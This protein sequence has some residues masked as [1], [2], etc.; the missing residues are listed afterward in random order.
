[1]PTY[2]RLAVSYLARAAELRKAGRLTESLAPLR[3]ALALEPNNAFICHDLG[4]TLLNCGQPAPAAEALSRAIATK[5]D[6]AAAHCRLG[7]ALAASG[8]PDKAIAAL[9]E[10]I[11]RDPQQ[12]EAHAALAYLLVE[13]GQRRAGAE[14]YRR[15][16]ALGRG[17][18]AGRI[19]LANALLIE[20]RDSEAESQLRRV[21]ALDPKNS[22]ARW[23]LGSVLSEG[24][25]FDL[26]EAE[27]AAAVAADPLQAVAW[28]DLVRCRRLGPADRPLID[29]MKAALP[30]LTR[31]DR[32]AL[33]HLA[34]GKA[35]DDLGDAGAAMRHFTAGNAAKP[36]P[37]QFDRRRLSERF[38]ALIARF[39]PELFD[40]YRPQANSSELPVLI[41]GLPRSGTTLVEQIVTSHPA[42]RGGGELLFW[43]H[44]ARAFVQV[45]DD[46]M[47]PYA[48]SRIAEEGLRVLREVDGAAMRITDKMPSNF[49]WAG[50][51]HLVFPFARIIH[52]R[53]SPIDTCLSMFQT[54][55]A[56]RPDFSTKAEDLVF[57]HAQYERL[58]AHWRAVLPSDRFFEVEYETLIA[59]SEPTTRRL[60]AFLGLEWDESCLHPERNSRRVK[61]ASKWQA[62]Q[63]IYTTALER[64]RRYE[65]FLG[66]FRALLPASATR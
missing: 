30:R 1:M 59:E 4:L 55:F 61:T 50:L 53:R 37:Y 11:A 65:P 44:E 48:M 45:S 12:A 38:D 9:Q 42:V 39:T 35:Y 62:R 17:S 13:R 5:P 2:G 58:M 3:Q 64:W 20:E 41:L 47:V 31:A 25:R 56:P 34:L 54:Y 16:G 8:Q 19:N 29:R 18:V 27:F 15:A 49:R 36:D 14:A 52:C 46:A 51:I 23:M 32:R 43:E 66:P 33:M 60:I 6:F 22:A 7:M 63:P 40:R 10:A 26:A 57:Y 24:G 28:Y 21:V